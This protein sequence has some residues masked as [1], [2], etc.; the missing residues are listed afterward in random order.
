MSTISLSIFLLFIVTSVVTEEEGSLPVQLP[1][2]VLEGESSG[3]YPSVE[4]L[5]QARN[6][7]KEKIQTVLE[8]I[9]IFAMSMWWTW[10]IA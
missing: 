2:I 5:D 9:G 10:T 6:D 4:V 3:T 7:T 8:Q 1:P